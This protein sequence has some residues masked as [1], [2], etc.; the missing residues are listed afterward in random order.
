MWEKKHEKERKASN[1]KKELV[2][3]IH[4]KAMAQYKQQVSDLEKITKPLAMGKPP[5]KIQLSP[6]NYYSR[7]KEFAINDLKN[8]HQVFQ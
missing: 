7:S 5:Y 3:D 2:N 1:Y 4:R 8:H 6:D